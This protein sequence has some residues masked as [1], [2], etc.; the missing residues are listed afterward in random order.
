MRTCDF[1]NLHQYIYDPRHE[2]IQHSPP[3]LSSHSKNDK[4]QYFIN[5]NL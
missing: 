1:S 2:D 5:V 3:A 4:L